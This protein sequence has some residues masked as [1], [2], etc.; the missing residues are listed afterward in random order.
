MFGKQLTYTIL[1]RQKVQKMAAKNYLRIT[2]FNYN[3]C[4]IKTSLENNVQNSVS[5]SNIRKRANAASEEILPIV[6]NLR[7]FTRSNI[8]HLSQNIEGIYFT[9]ESANL[10]P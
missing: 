10:N 8:L 2:L 7:Y 4:T 9:M 5:F 1:L 3:F 6:L